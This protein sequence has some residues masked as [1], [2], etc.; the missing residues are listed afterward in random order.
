MPRTILSDFRV[1][2]A[3][4]RG[5]DKISPHLSITY[6]NARDKVYK[7]DKFDWASYTEST[8]KRFTQTSYRIGERHDQVRR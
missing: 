3:I 6:R 4:F 5:F 7:L 8:P 2:T 1:F